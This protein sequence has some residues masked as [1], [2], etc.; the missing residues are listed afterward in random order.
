[1]ELI[2]ASIITNLLVLLFRHGL[3]YWDTKNFFSGVHFSFLQTLSEFFST[4]WDVILGRK[5]EISNTCGPMQQVP[6]CNKENCGGE[7]EI[8][9]GEINLVMNRLGMV[10]GLEDINGSK[11]VLSVDDFLALFEE[12]EPSFEEI[13][14]T[15]GVFDVNKDGFIDAERDRA[16]SGAK[17]DNGKASE[18]GGE[19]KAREATSMARLAA[20][21]RAA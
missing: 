11:S 9:T 10:G 5:V 12:E 18:G 8:H 4:T 2:V 16:S 19:G 15:F 20:R 7:N 21:T 13:K 1:M 17:S 3:N 14:E 6:S